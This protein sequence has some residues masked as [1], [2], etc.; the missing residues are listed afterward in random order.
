[1]WDID[2]FEQKSSNSL[3]VNC[4]PPS[5]TIVVGRPSIENIEFQAEITFL[6]V[7]LPTFMIL[8]KGYL[9]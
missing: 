4:G 2:K 9:E 3:D 6:D 8:T 7:V 5:V 1:M